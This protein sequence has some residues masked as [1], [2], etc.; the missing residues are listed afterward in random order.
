[1]IHIRAYAAA[2]IFI[3]GTCHGFAQTRLE[4]IQE[5]ISLNGMGMSGMPIDIRN[6][7]TLQNDEKFLPRA[8]NKNFSGS[9]ANEGNFAGATIISGG[10]RMPSLVSAD[11]KPFLKWARIGLPIVGRPTTFKLGSI[12]EPPTIDEFGDPL[13][14][15][16]KADS[17]LIVNGGE[18]Y[19]IGDI[20]ELLG[21]TTALTGSNAK[22]SR[23]VVKEAISSVS[24]VPGIVDPGSGYVV[25]DIVELVEGEPVS[26]DS[27]AKFV[28]KA[29]N[30][31]GGVTQF[32]SLTHQDSDSG[33]YSSIP[34]VTSSLTTSS[35][36]GSGSGL[37]VN[38]S[39]TQG[40]VSRLESVLHEDAEPGEY[41]VPPTG[42]ISTTDKNGGSG[43]SLKLNVEFT[44]I[45]VKP[46]DYWELMPHTL[47]EVL[48]ATVE[49]S[50]AVYNTGDE[51]TVENLPNTNN[52]NHAILKVTAVDDNS[53]IISLEVINGGSYIGDHNHAVTATSAQGKG[54]VRLILNMGFR[55]FYWS[56]HANTLY[57]NQKG[58]VTITWKRKDPVSS[59]ATNTLN[60]V[61]SNYLQAGN[62]NNFALLTRHY[63]V[64]GEPVNVDI[65]GNAKSVRQIYWTEKNYDGPPVS[66][67][68]SQVK[69]VMIAYSRDFPQFVKQEVSGGQSINTGD[70]TEEKRT[71]WYDYGYLHAYNKMGRVLVEYLGELKEGSSSGER[72]HLGIDIVE[73]IDE[74]DSVYFTTEVGE[75]IKSPTGLSD[76]ILT[77][78]VKFK[79]SIDGSQKK[80]ENID[81]DDESKIFAIAETKN[82]NEVSI[83]WMEK[84]VLGLDWPKIFVRYNIIWPDDPSKYSFF[85]TKDASLKP[86]QDRI[87][88][89]FTTAIQLPHENGGT[90]VSQLNNGSNTGSGITTDNK[91]Y[92]V[93]DGSVKENFSLIRN[94]NKDSVWFERVYS[95]TDAVI[96]HPGIGTGLTYYKWVADPNNGFNG[97]YSKENAVVAKRIESPIKPEQTYK[98]GEYL[99][100]Y[101]D[102][103][104]NDSLFYNPNA[105][106]N[107]YD[108]GFEDASKGAII[109]VNSKPT[110]NTL[111]IWWHKKS[112]KKGFD[113]IY[114]PS[115]VV[116]YKIH[117][118]K[119]VSESGVNA[120]VMASN[121]GSGPLD[122]LQSKGSIY[123][124]P[125]D[126]KPGYNP[127]EEHAVMFGGQLY[128]L[129]SQYTGQGE[130]EPFVLLEYIEDDGRPAMRAFKVLS[131]LGNLIFEYEVTAG[132]IL[133]PPMPLPLMPKPLYTKV[134][135]ALPVSLNKELTPMKAVSSVP[136]S[137]SKKV[138]LTLDNFSDNGK[139]FTSQGSPALNATQFKVDTLV[140]IQNINAYPSPVEKSKL[141]LITQEAANETQEA[142]SEQPVIHGHVYDY[143]LY[144]YKQPEGIGKLGLP[145][146]ES[147]DGPLDDGPLPLYI[148]T[149]GRNGKSP[150]SY[151]AGG[152]AIRPGSKNILF[153]NGGYEKNNAAKYPTDKYFVGGGDLTLPFT[154]EE[155]E[156]TFPNHGSSDLWLFSGKYYHESSDNAWSS[157]DNVFWFTKKIDEEI[158]PYLTKNK[159]FRIIITGD[160]VNSETYLH[161]DIDPNEL[162]TIVKYRIDKDPE[163][164]KKS[165]EGTL[166][167]LNSGTNANA[168]SAKRIP[169][170]LPPSE[171]FNYKYYQ[172]KNIK[173]FAEFPGIYFTQFDNNQIKDIKEKD[174]FRIVIKTNKS[175]RRKTWLATVLRVGGINTG[176]VSK[177]GIQYRLNTKE[178]LYKLHPGE[179]FI[180][181]FKP[182]TS[183]E[184][185]YAGWRVYSEPITSANLEDVTGYTFNDR[186]GNTW[187]YRAPVNDTQVGNF[188]YKY[189]YENREEFDQPGATEKSA[190][191]FY[192]NSGQVVTYSPKWPNEYPVMNL[193]QTL[194]SPINGL[195]D[196]RGQSSL[197]VLY[198][199]SIHNSPANNLSSVK[200]HDPTREKV[201][202]LGQGQQL[203][204]IPR[205]IQTTNYEGKLFFIQLPPHFGE[206]FYYDPNRGEQGALIFKGKFVDQ[207]VGQDYLLTNRI[208]GKDLSDMI[209]LCDS[210]DDDFDKWKYAIENLSTNI[211]TFVPNQSKPGTYHYNEVE[212]K[213]LIKELV[214]ITNDDE[215]VDSYA[216]TAI[217]GGAGFVTLIAGDGLAFTPKD[218]PVSMHIIKVVD[219]LQKAEIKAFLPDN[220]LS[221]KVT[222]RT[223]M[224]FAGQSAE[225]YVFEWKISPPI[226]SNPP[227]IVGRSAQK[228]IGDGSWKHLMYPKSDEN[229][230]QCDDVRMNDVLIVDQVKP[231]SKIHIVPN[232]MSTVGATALTFETLEADYQSFEAS[233]TYHVNVLTVAG[234]II[235]AQLSKTATP[236]LVKIDFNSTSKRPSIGQVSSIGEGGISNNKPQS[237]LYR[238]IP[239]PNTNNE[240]SEFWLSM[241]LDDELWAEVFVD[242]VSKV[243][244][245]MPSPTPNNTPPG[246][247][248]DPLRASWRLTGVEDADDDHFINVKVDLYSSSIP[249][250]NEEFKLRLHG[251]RKID[252]TTKSGSP[253]ADFGSGSNQ[254]VLGDKADVRALSDNYV[255][256]KY[257]AKPWGVTSISIEEGQTGQTITS[258][259]ESGNTATVTTTDPHPF[260]TGDKVTISGVSSDN[261]GTYNAEHTV[262]RTSD[263]TFTMTVTGSPGEGTGGT[264][265][266]SNRNIATV[267][268]NNPHP[269]EKGDTVVISEVT[270]S[271]YKEKLNKQHIITGVNSADNSFTISVAA[272]ATTQPLTNQGMLVSRSGQAWSDWT[273]PQLVEGWV[274]R[275]LAGI[276]PFQQRVDNLFSNRV[277]TDASMLTQA[278]PRW[279]GDVA[280]NMKN[281]NDFGLIEINKFRIQARFNTG[282]T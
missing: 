51:I 167:V 248:E 204:E 228:I 149:P 80:T 212:N 213:K 29:V 203:Q 22:K 238:R 6:N 8:S 198:Q 13:T 72:V 186:K 103:A 23:F 7:Q 117:Y 233:A 269:F 150:I 42:A 104:N 240:F 216:L 193:A 113:P 115:M 125:D 116:D 263:T 97:I 86:V 144:S 61:G 196:V 48:N 226:D 12:I 107:P 200:L 170:T 180:Y 106:I 50:P 165:L 14:R 109:P 222:V 135:G 19:G 68:N 168:L 158:K 174:E 207:P 227:K 57:A 279:E 179:Q 181:L 17:A 260:K 253:W 275:V 37:Q 192:V 187:V 83:F 92:V 81:I 254:V 146:S 124:Q 101:I 215:S 244:A 280:L 108:K 24:S 49:F 74:A 59:T 64:S 93:I 128:A 73:V 220:P 278:G 246:V 1:M 110:N 28:I 241:N 18:N 46:E 205:S 120:I 89:A 15:T 155:I 114:W 66:V 159:S 211:E 33:T 230:T 65:N 16:Q 209:F 41:S 173:A 11:P 171:K 137:G 87:N 264:M 164:N 122:S 169:G 183:S 52:S 123:R 96:R 277:N 255:I 239:W 236:K 31:A 259:A 225:D 75:Q 182:R 266:V 67:P 60:P 257:K 118:P 235:K 98:D 261:S 27:K 102:D 148:D 21:G 127:N 224:D 99:A 191:L 152:D 70:S 258:I 131:E 130:S 39:F 262:T 5:K 157:G 9:M 56:A 199:Q 10:V 195:P 177:T 138:K 202:Y 175:N 20:V 151:S 36:I 58:P 85:I 133:Q 69:R 25:G 63:V 247:V 119:N 210:F 208:T 184:N 166:F 71:L 62:N 270:N 139:R 44:D 45:V 153:N 163:V 126:T 77:P 251:V 53:K 147:D 219:T 217:G 156:K 136:V 47:Y 267:T 194:T 40:I 274:K 273:E 143:A 55:D 142:A 232:T 271:S 34:T 188:K 134:S 185:E 141:M 100:G 35:V 54:D 26:S 3:I 237:I 252:E 82:V 282:F 221:E 91:F 201:F 176:G 154:K 121:D 88:F 256:M 129:S 265:F 112:V 111:K 223:L 218:D 32:E 242:G 145:K 160:D 281:I 4:N 250:T 94:V 172:S 189:Q 95:T 105:Y 197:Q 243:K 272:A 78:I 178:S 234:E 132:S 276:N 245:N 231:V 214:E 76:N 229:I 140:T 206:R 2:L 268:T 30:A 84:G 162:R 43:N 249:G 161:N 190:H 90:L 38:V 79:I